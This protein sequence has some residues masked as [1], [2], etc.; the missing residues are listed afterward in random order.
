MNECLP[1]KLDERK[2]LRRKILA[3]KWQ[4]ADEREIDVRGD[5]WAK[6][7]IIQNA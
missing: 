1:P 5:E 7:K 6:E 3:A 4:T 2:V